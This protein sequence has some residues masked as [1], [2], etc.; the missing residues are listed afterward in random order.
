MI[1]PTDPGQAGK[2][3]SPASFGEHGAGET[4]KAPAG[5]KAPAPDQ[6]GSHSP[7]DDLREAARA[8]KGLSLPDWMGER[9]ISVLVKENA[10]AI[11][12]ELLAGEE[13]Q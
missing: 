9:I 3:R 13:A 10:P 11:A 8:I 6:G 12:R 4:T 5:Y 7:I 2:K 1:A